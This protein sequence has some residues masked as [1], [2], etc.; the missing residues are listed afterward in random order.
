G[1]RGRL[2][3]VPGSGRR[4]RAGGRGRPPGGGGGPGRGGRERGVHPRPPARHGPAPGPA[5]RH[6]PR[7]VAAADGRVM[8]PRWAL[9]L[10]VDWT[11][12]YRHCRYPA[13]EVSDYLASEAALRLGP[14]ARWWLR[15]EVL[16]RVPA[17]LPDRRNAAYWSAR[18]ELPSVRCGCWAVF[19]VENPRE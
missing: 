15:D 3:H 10:P 11:P 1:G 13:G 4:S 12:R 9:T 2:P 17:G 14:L 19:A 7:G 6:A 5:G 18:P 8:T 16:A